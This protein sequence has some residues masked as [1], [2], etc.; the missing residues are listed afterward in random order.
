MPV[1]F[2]TK[3][4]RNRYGN[5]IDEPTNEQLAVYFLL[6]DTDKKAAHSHRGDYNRIGFAIQLGTVR[7]LGTFLPNPLKIPSNIIHY[8]SQ[9]LE[10]SE[11]NL[12]K[13]SY[14]ESRWDHTREIRQAYGYHDFMMQPHHFRLVRW[15]YNHFWLAPERP[16]VVFDLTM[17]RL[18]EQ[19]IL[20][21][22]ATVLERLISQI[23]E[24]ATSRLW[25]KLASLADVNQRETLENL[26]IIDAKNKTGLEMLRQA[27]THESPIGFLKA[28]KRFKMIY[29]IGAYQW[30]ISRIPIGRISVLS[31]Y[32][33]IARS[34]TI[35]R[36]PDERRIATLVAFAITYTTSS[37]DDIIDYMERYFSTL[38]N[39]AN[40][41]GEKERLRSLKDLDSSARE[42]SKACLLL[43]DE[44]VPDE[45]IRKI[46]FSNIP[47]ERLKLAIGMIDTITR[48]IDQ[49][50]EYKELFRYYTSIRRFLPALL[51]TIKFRASAAGQ[52]AL[53]A[54][55]FLSKVES[56]TGKNKFSDAPTDGISASWK[57]VVFKGDSI[58]S[59]PYTF[60]AIE[61][62]LEGI[63]NYDIYLKK[64]D[65]YNDPRSN[66]LQGSAWKSVKS[67]VLSTLG[68]SSNAEESLNPLKKNLDTTF[69]NTIKNWDDNPD[70]RV[71]M[72]KGKEKIVLSLINRLE[73]PKSLILLKKQVESLMPNTDLPGLLMEINALTRFTDQFTH[74]SQGNSRIKDLSVSICA[75]FIAKACNIGLGPVVQPGIPALEYD[76]LTWV[77]QNYF[78][79]ETITQA[80]AVLADHISKMTLA[81]SWGGGEVASADGIRFVVPPKTIYA[82]PNPRYFGI[83]RGI[84]SYDLISDQFAGLNKLVITGTIRDS[85]YLLELVLGQQTTSNPREIMTDTA[86]YSDII[87]GV[88][89]LLGYRFSPRLA[90]IG[91]TRLWRFDPNADY[92]VLN[93]LSKHKLREDLIIKSWDDMLRVAGSLKLGT[94]N[95][96]NLIKMLQRGGKPTMLGRA[97]GEF[98]R[99]FKTTYELS[100]LDDKNYRRRIL[101]QLNRGES[102]NG[103][104]RVVVYGKKGEIHQPHREDQEDQ[105]NTLGLVTNAIILWN[106]VYMEKALDAIR[107][108]GYIVNLDDV[109]R[110]SPLGY[111]HINIVGHYSFDLAKKILSGKLRPLQPMNK[112]LFGKKR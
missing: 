19:K 75:I 43:L 56:K 97:M 3:E 12:E 66:L 76:R 2:L 53:A 55:D 107:N 90:D 61:K 34:Q 7:F 44:T 18:I 87:F 4:Q 41:K 29:S 21:P 25:H 71:E 47:K 51:A 33:S 52:P 20:L 100:F 32:A 95:P 22:G 88:F 49:T 8:I 17:A 48:P 92:G 67:K 37:Q 23:R 91:S 54:W 74:I 70:V 99:I 81:K 80:N 10:L 101:T 63:K 31:R 94:I 77:E 28:I 84:T 46:I 42:L 36:M 64:S 57:R 35:K 40:R 72:V 6:D 103:L 9:Q 73:E 5:F 1:E 68:W 112:K 39:G 45:T 105:L 11:N 104:K 96:T 65:R 60:W 108:A 110:L 13:Y 85:L 38:F 79:T 16:S 69:K 102:E 89:A 106:T 111:D 83:G 50:V 26:L 24:R 58:S 27:V 62:M 109:K 86:G 93:S 78:R 30:N 59:C 82:G 15:L 14:S 98:G